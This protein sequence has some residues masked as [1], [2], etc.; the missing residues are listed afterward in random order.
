MDN[1]SWRDEFELTWD[2][3]PK[4]TRREIERALER[5]PGG[6]KGWKDLIDQAIRQ[7]RLAAGTRRS[8]VILGPANAGKSTLYNAL[9]RSSETPAAVSAIPGTTREV[10]QADAGVFSLVDTPGTDSVGDL[11]VDE[12]N[13]A[14]AAARRSDLIVLLFD[15]AH[16]VRDREIELH[17][18]V[19]GFGKP[20]VVALNKMDLIRNERQAVLSQAAKS[21]DLKADELLPISALHR[22]GLTQLLL[23][24]VRKEPEILA[25]LGEA[26]PA[27][28]WKL[29]QAVIARGA[30]AAAAVGVT[31]LPF[32]DFIPLLGIQVA[33][34]LGIARVFTYRITLGR[35]RELI[36]TFGM[37][38]L[39][40]TLFYELSKFGGPP[41]WLLAAGVAAGTTAALG[42]GAALWFDRG[43]RLTNA[44]L[45]ALA[46]NLSQGLVGRLKPF[47]KRRPS[48]DEMRRHVGEVL[49]AVGDDSEGGAPEAESNA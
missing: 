13:K 4:Q 24:M 43:E 42:Y 5:L 26:L 3:L 29:A 18:E 12:R 37:G 34:V 19:A 44:R 20:M 25:A 33:M 9:I 2:E 30:S 17:R 15:A 32:I 46:T 8:V 49:Q 36:A 11:G 35:A 38:A 1:S 27:Y 45:K 40:R 21:L 6:L 39:G 16:G 10:Q 48:D 7:V 31:P 14:L 28:R 41:G 47:G 23:E 22:Q